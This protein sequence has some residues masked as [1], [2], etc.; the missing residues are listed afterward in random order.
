[1]S[2]F[3]ELMNAA[4]ILEEIARLPEEEQGKVIEFVRQLPNAE[5]ILLLASDETL[6]EFLRDHAFKGHCPNCRECHITPGLA[7]DLSARRN[8]VDPGQNQFA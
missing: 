5:T 7:F 6:P 4:E 3:T 8:G 1:M 2:Q